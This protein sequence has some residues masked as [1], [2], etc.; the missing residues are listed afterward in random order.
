MAGRRHALFRDRMIAPRPLPPNLILKA[1][2]QD[3]K[4]EVWCNIVSFARGVPKALRRHPNIKLGEGASR[5]RKTLV[6]IGE[7]SGATFRR[8]AVLGGLG[9]VH[10]GCLGTRGKCARFTGSIMRSCLPAR[11]GSAASPSPGGGPRSQIP[12]TF[13]GRPRQ[14][15][16]MQQN[17]SEPTVNQQ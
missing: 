12:L 4:T 17:H 10:F 7:E 11:G 14:P 6:E 1:N 13:D 8:C 16:H 9:G 3:D 15:R 5:S 2:R